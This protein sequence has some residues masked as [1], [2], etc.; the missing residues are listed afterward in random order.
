[1]SLDSDRY[2]RQTILPGIGAAG[3]ARLAAAHLLVV[4]AG[5]LGVPV[6]QYLV[7]A[8][9]GRI[10][11]ID[12]DIAEAGNL[13]RQ[14]IFGP[15]L[16]QPKAEAAAAFARSLNPQVAVVPQVAWLTPA[17]APGLVA[18]AD[19][20]L[21]CADSFAASYILSDVCLAAGRPLISASALGF[22]GYVGGFCGTAPSLRAVFPDLPDTLATCA[23]AGA[24]GPVVGMLGLI[25]AQ[26]ALAVLLGLAPSPLG[27]LIRYDMQGFRSSGFRFDAAPEPAEIFAFVAKNNL[28]DNDFIVELRDEAEAPLA[29]VAQAR[30]H[31]VEE[32]GPLGPR[33]AAGQRAVFACRSGLRAWRAAERLRPHW[34][35]PIALLADPAASTGPAAIDPD[36]LDQRTTR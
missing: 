9:I 13:H 26:M 34:P 36:P 12:P 24:L 14:P 21:D 35:G 16:G 5:G 30:R 23:T 20:A 15:Y 19:L 4:G 22:S 10:T 1:M 31:R 6:L 27:Q 3:Q 18:Q 7:G 17:N 33:P 32:F 11:L 2:A 28:Q 8:G 29:A 25:Q